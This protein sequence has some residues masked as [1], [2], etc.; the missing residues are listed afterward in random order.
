MTVIHNVTPATTTEQGSSGMGFLLGVI[1][2]LLFFFFLI[3]YGLPALRNS[4]STPQI[5][6]PDKVDVNINQPKSQ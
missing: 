2:L 6:V 5:N 1:A 3:Y 4:T